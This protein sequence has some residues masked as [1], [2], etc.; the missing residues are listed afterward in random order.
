[1][2]R[3]RAGDQ[4]QQYLRAWPGSS[5]H[6]RGTIAYQQKACFTNK[7]ADSEAGLQGWLNYREKFWDLVNELMEQQGEHGYAIGNCNG[8][9]KLGKSL[10]TTYNQANLRNLTTY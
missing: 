8:N 4:L 1:M 9:R 3:K 2:G 10:V 7:H 5:G 6:A